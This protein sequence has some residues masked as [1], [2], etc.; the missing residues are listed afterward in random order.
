ADIETGSKDTWWKKAAPLRWA[1]YV[2]LRLVDREFVKWRK[3]RISPRKFRK[4]QQRLDRL[5]P[6][7]R[8]SAAKLIGRDKEYNLLLDSFRLHVLKHPMLRKWFNK[9]ELPKAICL[10]GE[11]GTGKTFLTMVSLKQM[12]LEAH[13]NGIFLSPIIIKGSDVFSEYYGR[14]TKQ[15]GKILEQASSAPSVVYIDE[16]QSFGRKVRGETGTELE[17]TRLQDE[18]NRWLD[19]ITTNEARTLVIVATN[20]YE[21]TREDIRRRLTR[22]DLDSGVTREMLLAIVEDRATAEGWRGISSAEILEVLER[23]AVLRRHGSITPN[24]ILGVFREVKR[25]KE[26]PLLETIRRSMPSPLSKWTKP[27]YKV[28]LEDFAQAAHSMKFYVEREKSREITDAVYLVTPKVRRDEIGGLHDIRDKVLNHISLAFSQKM[29]ELGYASNCRFLLFGPPGT[30]KTLLALVAAAENKV[31]FIKVR[32]GELMSGAA[33]IGEPEKRIKDLFSL[34]RQRSPCILFLD[35]ADA[36]FWGADPTGNK[37]LAQVKAELSEIKPDE[38]IVVIAASNKEN[39]IDQATRDRFEPN[40]YYVHPPLNDREWHEVVD[41]HLRRFDRFMHPEVD[42]TKITRLFRMQRILSPRAASETIA[43][44]H[45]LWASEIS[46]VCELRASKD[47]AEREAVEKKYSTDLNRLRSALESSHIPL[48]ALDKV[49][50]S[51]YPIRLYHFEKAIEALESNQARQRREMEEA[52][53][54]TAPTPGASFGLYATEDGTGGIIT[55]QCSVRPMIPGERQVSVTGNAT[56]AVIG[57]SV[58]SD[59]SVLQSA[60][61]ATEAISSLLWAVS[62][63]DL[64]RLHIHFQIRSI[65]EGAPGQGVSGPSAGLAMVLA[66]LSELAGLPISPATVATGTIGVK[67]DVGPVGGLGGYG[68]Q[69]GKIV[70]ILK[71]QKIR[72]TDLVLPAANFETAGDEMR[73]LTEEGVHVRPV[74][75]VSECLKIIFDRDMHEL[76]AKI[77]ERF[78]TAQLVARSR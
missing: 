47:R 9:D 77:R 63:V 75:N 59:E 49:D 73:I 5:Y 11:S 34:A 29:S 26:V 39:L 16:F 6:P 64:S 44:A 68:A 38:G 35:E 42:A 53:I 33:Y 18:I 36:I 20:S 41:I 13:K 76:V 24:D 55:V 48:L 17:D 27:I 32:G 72:V 22:V 71:A 15:L 25:A 21:Q 74:S 45:R 23:E 66:L 62:R 56:S 30:G 46:A 70:G 52:L 19:K 61:N 60:E 57:Q 40:V 2:P 10:T 51:N 54:L 65:L 8:F 69:T 7:S 67:L 78:E 37:I 43:E 4:I 58:V 28:S 50:E 12:L 3:S 1:N 31:A 14:S